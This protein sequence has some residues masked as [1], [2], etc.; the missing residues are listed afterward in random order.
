MKKHI[1]SIFSLIEDWSTH[2]LERLITEITMLVE[3]RYKEEEKSEEE[4]KL[5]KNYTID[6]LIK[7]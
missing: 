3:A 5:K 4:E 2:D 6:D 7:L 1:N